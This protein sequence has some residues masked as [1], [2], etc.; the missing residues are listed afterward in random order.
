MQTQ[1][2]VKTSERRDDTT[3]EIVTLFFLCSPSCSLESLSSIVLCI[4]TQHGGCV[5]GYGYKATPEV[6]T[7]VPL[8]CVHV[9]V[10]TSHS[11][12]LLVSQDRDEPPPGNAGGIQADPNNGSPPP[13]PGRPLSG[14]NMAVHLKTSPRSADMKRVSHKASENIS[15]DSM[16]SENAN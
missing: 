13:P 14:V 10:I 6:S 12:C 2:F 9:D 1:T 11:G 5:S 7:K 16:R 15:T 8:C 3:C 4:F